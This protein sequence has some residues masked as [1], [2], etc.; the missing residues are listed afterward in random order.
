MRREA[1]HRNAFWARVDK[2]WIEE[3]LYAIP[4]E[5]YFPARSPLVGKTAGVTTSARDF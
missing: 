3:V 4:A 5:V 2:E 1:F